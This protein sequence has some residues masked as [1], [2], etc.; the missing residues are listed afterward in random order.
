METTKNTIKPL[1][2]MQTSL[3]TSLEEARSWTEKNKSTGC[4]CPCCNQ[5]L[6]VYKRAL[7]SV[8]SRCLIRLYWLDNN[9]K[10]YH[11]V[12][13]IVEGISDTGTND[14]SKLKHY[15]LI[16]EMPKDLSNTKT[17]TSGFWKITEKGRLYVENKISVESHIYLCNASLLGFS[18]TQT[19]I[20]ES[21]GKKF[22]Y[23]ELMK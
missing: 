7:N 3:F 5:I 14:F 19:N 18:T 1:R 12:K 21:I 23:Q 13:K 11:H 15:S 4:I 16:E 10:N 17:R 6:K 20:I 9:D 22:N 2:K 8:M